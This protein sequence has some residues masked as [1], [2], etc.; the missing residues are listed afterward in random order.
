MFDFNPKWYRQSVG[1][2][3]YNQTTGKDACRDIMRT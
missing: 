1:D 2:Q 3:P